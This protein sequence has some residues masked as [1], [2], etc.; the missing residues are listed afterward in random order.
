VCGQLAA[1]TDRIDHPW[2]RLTVRRGEAMIAMA[3]RDDAAAVGTL[4]PLLGEYEALGQLFERARLL[5][6]LGGAHRR[7]GQRRTARTCL[8]EAVAI[9]EEQ[10]R[11]GWAAWA[12]AE[13]ARV[14][15]RRSDGTGLTP[16]EEAVARLVVVGHTNKQ[17]AAELFIT[18]STVEVTLS[19]VYR[20][21]GIAG[22]AQLREKLKTFQ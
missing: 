1:L 19:R 16:A 4:E 14:P 22:R 9:L 11:P 17:V 6:H 20:K 8:T 10:G 13:L 5:V 12:Q 21:L 18:V 2:G 7:L 3:E 15:G